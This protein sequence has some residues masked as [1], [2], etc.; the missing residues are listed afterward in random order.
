MSMY[1]V[2]EVALYVRSGRCII[3]SPIPAIH[4]TS[5]VQYADGGK[6][7]QFAAHFINWIHR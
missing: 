5:A 3:P 4:V 1:L 6:A 7:A 2:E